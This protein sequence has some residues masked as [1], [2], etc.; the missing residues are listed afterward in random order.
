VTEVLQLFYRGGGGSV[1][2]RYRDPNGNWQDEDDLGGGGGGPGP[3]T[4][5]PVPGEDVLQLFYVGR[6]GTGTDANILTRWLPA[7]GTWSGEKSLSAQIPVYGTIAAAQVPDQNVLQLF[8]PGTNGAIMT[9]WREANGNWSEEETI[10]AKIVHPANPSDVVNPKITA[11][12]VPGDNILRLFYVGADGTLLT[13]E[14]DPETGSWGR[15]QSLGG[16]PDPHS[17]IAAATLPGQ[18]GLTLLY[19]DIQSHLYVLHPEPDGNWTTAQGVISNR[20][21]YMDLSVSLVPG[22]NALQLVYPG[23]Q[24]TTRWLASDGTL[25][26]EVTLTETPAAG[27]VALAPVPGENVVQAFYVKENTPGVYTRWGSEGTWADERPLPNQSTTPRLITAVDLN[28]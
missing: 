15:E 28:L 21:A 17:N 11:A 18:N 5:A 14:R 6:I 1:V 10:A 4:A 8:Y 13:Q 7:G 27:D 3:I 23:Q 2:F 24:V 9:R 20:L 25:S 19:F 16:R 22:Q 26:D 12:Q